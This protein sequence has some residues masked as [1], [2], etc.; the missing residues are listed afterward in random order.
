MGNLIGVNFLNNIQ[1]QG[2][3]YFCG[4]VTFEANIYLDDVEKKISVKGRYMVAEIQ[5]NGKDAAKL[6]VSETADISAFLTKGYNTISIRITSSMR[7]MLGPLH[8]S[9]IA[10]PTDYVGHQHFEFRGTWEE[11]LSPDF[12]KQL[13]N[14]A[15]WNQF[16]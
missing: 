3:P 1:T 12:Y 15:L 10:E 7:N 16:C 5:V 8:Y 13:S 11:D 14:H 2:Y 4:K 9:H 6:I